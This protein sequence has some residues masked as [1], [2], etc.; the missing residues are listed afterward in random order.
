M[1]NKTIIHKKNVLPA[2]F[3]TMCK[4]YRTIFF[5]NY[6]FLLLLRLGT[7]GDKGI[8]LLASAMTKRS[9]PDEESS[10]DNTDENRRSS[11]RHKPP[12]VA[13]PI[14]QV[15]GPLH[16]YV[17]L[18][19]DLIPKMPSDRITKSLEI[20]LNTIVDE[21]S[22]V[23]PGTYKAVLKG[24]DEQI[25]ALANPEAEDA[26]LTELMVDDLNGK[27]KSVSMI[28]QRL[29]IANVALKELLL[30]AHEPKK[31]MPVPSAFGKHW[32]EAQEGPDAILCLR[33][34]KRQ[35]LPLITLHEAFLCFAN[36]L[37]KPLTATD[38]DALSAAWRLSSSMAKSYDG[39][40]Q[41][42]R[43]AFNR[44]L[45]PFIPEE[46][47]LPEIV[48]GEMPGMSGRI[49][50]ALLDLDAL[51][52]DKG[53]PGSQGDPYMQIARGFQAFVMWKQSQD[54]RHGKAGVAKFLVVLFGASTGL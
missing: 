32:E 36:E 7:G 3:L 26:I 16:G 50:G 42:R 44:A 18:L 24:I 19:R 4:V 12:P 43:D 37:K 52:E 38:A 15:T 33:P 21:I 49:D 41:E 1:P 29:T 45:D 40:E 10:F 51:R 2:W 54:S 48:L 35:G 20:V 5:L 14:P 30:A 25:A 23:R 27:P 8:T 22:V 17:A 53:E 46:S 39:N 6:P 28:R 9:A 31:A 11:K 47:W 34:A 13:T